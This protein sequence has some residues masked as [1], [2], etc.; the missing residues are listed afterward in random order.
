MDLTN[1]QPQCVDLCVLESRD[2]FVPENQISAEALA[3]I[4]RWE[5]MSLQRG[6]QRPANYLSYSS[7]MSCPSGDSTPPSRFRP[8][9]VKYTN[10]FTKNE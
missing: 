8:R 4:A 1:M 3:M 2:D 10:Q 5:N 7:V 6:N 9:N